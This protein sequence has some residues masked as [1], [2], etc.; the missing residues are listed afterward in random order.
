MIRG[1]DS[2]LV[3]IPV[4]PGRG[5]LVAG[6]RGRLR[7]PFGGSRQN[8]PTRFIGP[9]LDLTSPPF[10]GAVNSSPGPFTGEPITENSSGRGGAGHGELFH[11]PI[12]FILFVRDAVFWSH[13]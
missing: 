7:R 2:N 3:G 1:A 8:F 9:A 12:P 6:H 5:R 13:S 10:Q 4:N 11:R